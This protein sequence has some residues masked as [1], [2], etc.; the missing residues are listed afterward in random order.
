MEFPSN[1]SSVT[2]PPKRG[3]IKIMIARD[4]LRSVTSS[5]ASPSRRSRIKTMI[6]R[7][8]VRSA[9]SIASPRTE[10]N[11]GEVSKRGGG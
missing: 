10:N 8:L 5:T 2:V 4:L 7:D 3:Q 9:S 11:I 6:A 1:I